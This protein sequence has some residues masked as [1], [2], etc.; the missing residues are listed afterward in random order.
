MYL[1][2]RI[3]RSIAQL[4][5]GLEVIYAHDIERWSRDIGLDGYLVRLRPFGTSYDPHV[6]RDCFDAY[7]RF[8]GKGKCLLDEF[9]GEWNGS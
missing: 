5:W 1:R 2:R 7:N 6:S 9:E 4:E 8:M 3:H